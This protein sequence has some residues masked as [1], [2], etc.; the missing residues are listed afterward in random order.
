M[1]KGQSTERKRVVVDASRYT[2]EYCDKMLR[3]FPEGCDAIYA[4]VQKDL[5]ILAGN[6]RPRRRW[7]SKP[8]EVPA[9]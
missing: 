3:E 7:K 6:R 2:P 5:A 9:P 1:P 4:Q 8:L